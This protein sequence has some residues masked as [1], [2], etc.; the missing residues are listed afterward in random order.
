MTPELLAKNLARY[1]VKSEQITHQGKRVRGFYWR[2][3]KPI[4]DRYL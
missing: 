3:L 2:K 4:F 1:K